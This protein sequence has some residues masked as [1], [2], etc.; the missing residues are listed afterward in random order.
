LTYTFDVSYSASRTIGLLHAGTATA[1]SGITASHRL[2]ASTLVDGGVYRV[3]A[4]AANAFASSEWPF[5][6]KATAD[7]II[8]KVQRGRAALTRQIKSTTDH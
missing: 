3:R 4:R 6:W 7:D 2:P 5:V 1:R 8:E